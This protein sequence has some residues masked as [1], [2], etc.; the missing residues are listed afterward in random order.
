MGLESLIITYSILQRSP[1]APNPNLTLLG[2]G[3]MPVNRSTVETEQ[4]SSLAV[5]FPLSTPETV[6]VSR[7]CLNISIAG[8][9]DKQRNTM[10]EAAS[11]DLGV[12]RQSGD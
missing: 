7:S 11:H 2:L 9:K 5:L 6:L 10:K 3:P 4:S 1:D 12:Q 8:P